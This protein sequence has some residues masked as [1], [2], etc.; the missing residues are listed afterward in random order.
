MNFKNPRPILLQSIARRTTDHRIKSPSETRKC[1]ETIYDPVEIQDDPGASR[2]TGHLLKEQETSET[3]KNTGAGG[4]EGRIGA[5]G[6]TRPSQLP[7]D[8]A[9]STLGCTSKVP[10]EKYK[11]A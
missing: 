2:E 4:G 1:L 6:T 8:A 5:R 9:E 11:C 3:V 7:S 10:S